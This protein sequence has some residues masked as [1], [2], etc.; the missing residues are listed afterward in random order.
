LAKA[1]ELQARARAI[2]AQKEAE[3]AKESEEM[4]KR[5]DKEIAAAKVKAEEQEWANAIEQRKREKAELEREKERM[6][7]QL[8]LDRRERFGGNPPPLEEKKPQKTPVEQIEHGITTVKTLYTEM[9]APGVAKL[10]LKT[11]CTFIR[12]LMKDPDNEKF[13]RINLDNEAVQKRVT[14]INGGMLILKGAGFTEAKDGSSFLVMETV[15]K[16]LLLKAEAL[17]KPHFDE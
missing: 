14:K 12:N 17:L 11:C 3:N 1:K 5:M 15:N 6:R 2:R 8:E 9:R 16:E 4:R 7:K 13:R 10:C